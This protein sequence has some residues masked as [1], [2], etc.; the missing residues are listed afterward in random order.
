VQ[1][2]LHPLPLDGI[3][4]VG[5]VTVDPDNSTSD[6]HKTADA[7]GRLLEDTHQADDT[8]IHVEPEH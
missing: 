6:A 8:S 2:A 7:L 1:G 4:A 5:L 3:H